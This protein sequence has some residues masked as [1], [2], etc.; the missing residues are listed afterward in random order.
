MTF[1]IGKYNDDG[2][3]PDYWT[4]VS[5]LHDDCLDCLAEARSAALTASVTGSVGATSSTGDGDVTFHEA[6][7]HRTDLMEQ[8]Q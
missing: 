8:P 3:E 5:W 1:G 4:V 7:V 6:R 2:T